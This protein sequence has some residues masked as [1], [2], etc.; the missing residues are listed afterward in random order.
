D[1]PKAEQLP[2]PKTLDVPEALLLTAR[3]FSSGYARG[4]DVAAAAYRLAA[5][6]LRGWG[7]EAHAKD[8][9]VAAEQA[10]GGLASEWIEGTPRQLQNT[11][12][13]GG[14]PRREIS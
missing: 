9:E 12:C 14:L 8:L 5:A 7:D 10:E 1:A 2:G 6:K 13:P 3:N 11:P 4:G